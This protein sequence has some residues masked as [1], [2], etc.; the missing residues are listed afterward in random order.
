MARNLLHSDEITILLKA[1][2]LG[3]LLEVDRQ[4]KPENS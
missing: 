3:D 1:L 4:V 2:A